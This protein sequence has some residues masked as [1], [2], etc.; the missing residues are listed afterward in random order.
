MD[1][2]LL[3]QDWRHIGARGSVID[4]IGCDLEEKEVGE[5]E[6]ELEVVE[7]EMAE[8]GRG[9]GGN[10]CGGRG[11][12]PIS[13]LNLQVQSSMDIST[14][15]IEGT[16]STKTGAEAAAADSNES[17][18]MKEKDEAAEAEAEGIGREKEEIVQTSVK[19][20]PAE[21]EEN[22]AT[23]KREQAAESEEQYE[24]TESRA[25]EEILSTKPGGEAEGIGRETEEITQ[26][27]AEECSEGNMKSDEDCGVK[28]LPNFVSRSRVRSL[29]TSAGVL[30]KTLYIILH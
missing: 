14:K 22:E 12:N 3:N 1:N 19:A 17:K 2:E 10:E 26:L 27:Y 11:I 6:A 23:K 7:G 9:K 16:Q 20:A 4:S 18:A 29:A 21:G 30:Q 8:E 24:P 5:E 25:R 15:E 28:S 13:Q